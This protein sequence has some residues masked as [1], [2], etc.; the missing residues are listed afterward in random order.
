MSNFKHLQLKK[1]LQGAEKVR[2]WLDYLRLNFK[3]KIDFFERL[4]VWLN[5]TNSNFIVQDSFTY[6]KINLPTG[7]ALKI[8]TVYNDIP[9]PIMLFQIFKSWCVSTGYGRLDFYGMFF[10]LVELGEI[11]SDYIQWIKNFV[12][13]KTSE[14][15][16]ITRVDYCFDMFYSEFQ[17]FQS[18]TKFFTEVNK[19]S[20]IYEISTGAWIQ[21]RSV[22]SKTAKRY[23]IRMYDKLLDISSKWKQ[24]F[25]GDYLKN[26]S[27]HRF[28][29]QF[30]PHFCRWYYLNTMDQM[31]NKMNSF[32]WITE[33][34]FEWS[35]FYEY[36]NH[37]DI[38]DFNKIFFTKMFNGKVQKFVNAGLNPYQVIY[39][40]LSVNCPKAVHY[41]FLFDINSTIKKIKNLS[42]YLW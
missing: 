42:D 41:P 32:L 27:V 13:S 1:T 33:A 37:F 11:P 18:Y 7:H 19:S 34:T 17:V 35:M 24:R 38:N 40:Y 4:F 2:T 20:K 22:W 29:V 5:T 12:Y 6:E 14:V 21:S 28:E 36:D 8:S 39:K 9:V 25:Y 10:R 31:M 16:Q 3:Q 23:V 30:W 15:P 26:K